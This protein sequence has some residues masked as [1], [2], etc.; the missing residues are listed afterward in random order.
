M[1]KSRMTGHRKDHQGRAFY[2]GCSQFSR[3]EEHRHRP[4]SCH[5]GEDVIGQVSVVRVHNQDTLSD[6]ARAYHLGYEEILHANPGVD[7]WLPGEGTRVILPTQ[8]IL[9]D[10]PR[11]GLVLNI[12][13]MRL[14]YYPKPSKGKPPMVATFPVSIG[15]MDWTTPLGLTRVTAKVINP[16]WY[17]PASIR[18]EHEQEGQELPPKVAAGPDNPLGQY[19]LQLGRT[20]YLI[21]GTDRPYGIGMRA[22][23]GCIRLY[24]RISSA[25]SRKCR[26][27]RRY[28]SSISRT[29]PGGTAAC[30]TSRP[31]AARRNL[32]EEGQPHT[33]VREWSRPR[34]DAPHMWIGTASSRGRKNER[35]RWRSRID[36]F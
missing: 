4:T 35:H 17:P 8:H 36:Y 23:H 11:V 5:G 2:S 29:R 12:P 33:R 1:E 31:T 6:I 26:S 18:A 24:R 20:G 9:P 27:V 32:A 34:A 16:A 14:Y 10:A 15:R 25:C 30:S 7:P 3:P 21:H 13:E 19:A 28:A 22:T